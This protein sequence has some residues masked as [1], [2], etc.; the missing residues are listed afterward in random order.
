MASTQE[1]RSRA[2]EVC[3]HHKTF[4]FVLLYIFVNLNA[5]PFDIMYGSKEILV[6]SLHRYDQRIR[7]VCGL[8]NILEGSPLSLSLLGLQDCSKEWLRPS[9]SD[10]SVP[11]LDFSKTIWHYPEFV[12]GGHFMISYQAKK[13]VAHTDPKLYLNTDL[14]ISYYDLR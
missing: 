12:M 13:S 3:W 11:K 9:N 8:G 1:P 7:D 2:I 4:V 6:G 10:H 14:L 5:G